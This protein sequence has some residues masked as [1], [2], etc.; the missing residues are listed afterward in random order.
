[1][2]EAK[3]NMDYAWRVVGVGAVMCGLAAWS[4]HDGAVYWPRINHQMAAA[5]PALMATNLT[6][7]AWL[8]ADLPG[9]SPLHRTFTVHGARA[10]RKLLRKMGELRL[11]RNSADLEQALVAQRQAVQDLLDQPLYTAGDIS[12][13]YVQG[14]LALALGLSIFGVVAYRRRQIYLADDSGLYGS[15][16][17]G[18]ARPWE[19]LVAVDWTRWDA[20]G[21]FIVRF[22]NGESF[23]CDGWHFAGMENIADEIREARPDLALNTE[24]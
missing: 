13:Q 7:E 20:K 14:V 11:P 16:F 21:I 5:R 9:D 19:E 23:K 18:R 10:P 8:R 3:L 15:G 12:G 17:G 4:F 1:M 24:R 2:A 6:A 22:K